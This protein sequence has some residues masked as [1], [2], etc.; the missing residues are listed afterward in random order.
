M[1]K[2]SSDVICWISVFNFLGNMLECPVSFIKL[3]ALIGPLIFCSYI[4]L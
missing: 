4:H 3:V 1:G 2:D